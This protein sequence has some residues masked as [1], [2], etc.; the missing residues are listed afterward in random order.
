MDLCEKGWY[1]TLKDTRDTQPQVSLFNMLIAT[2]KQCLLFSCK[3]TNG[4]HSTEASPDS[5]PA[6]QIPPLDIFPEQ[7]FK[8]NK[9]QNCGR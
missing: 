5:W 8:C 4:S 2:L 6:I 9:K 3:T 1:L 7:S